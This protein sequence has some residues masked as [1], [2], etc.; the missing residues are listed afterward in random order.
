M[1]QAALRRAVTARQYSAALRHLRAA[2]EH[3]RLVSHYLPG[4]GAT[5][6]AREQAGDAVAWVGDLL[7]ARHAHLTATEKP[8]AP[9]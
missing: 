4:E 9:T 6:M 1:N 5:A 7:A 2:Q 8:D 3:L